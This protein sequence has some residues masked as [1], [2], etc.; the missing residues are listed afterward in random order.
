LANENYSAFPL[1]TRHSCN[2]MVNW[3]LYHL[4][5]KQ[6]VRKQSEFEQNTYV[7]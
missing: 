7:G 5:E 3:F 1:A 4:K 2:L 6:T